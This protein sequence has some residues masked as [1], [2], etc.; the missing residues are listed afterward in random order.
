MQV[1][2]I[3][4]AEAHAWLTDQTAI[5]IDVRENDEYAAIHIPGAEHIPL[6]T[7]EPSHLNTTDKKIIIHCR[8]GHR[9]QIACDKLLSAGVEQT[10]YNMEGGILAWQVAG[11]A[12]NTQ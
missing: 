2:N 3:T 9:S 5:L 11:Y 4:V 6:V 1:H 12:V 8:S 7:I 10:L